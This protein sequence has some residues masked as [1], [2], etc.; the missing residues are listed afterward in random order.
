MTTALWLLAATAVVV[1]VI[2]RL[3]RANH[4]LETILREERD[5]SPAPVSTD[6]EPHE[7]GRHRRDP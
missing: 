7:V 5:R 1:F 6:D 2:W 4:T 3:R